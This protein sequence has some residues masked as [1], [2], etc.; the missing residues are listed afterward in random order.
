MDSELVNIHNLNVIAKKYM[1]KLYEVLVKIIGEYLNSFNGKLVTSW[2][3]QTY[4]FKIKCGRVL[5][6]V[7]LGVDNHND[8]YVVN[9]WGNVDIFKIIN[10]EI[11]LRSMPIIK[12]YNVIISEDHICTQSDCGRV[13]IYSCNNNL[14]IKHKF[15][16]KIGRRI[17]YHYNNE[18]YVTDEYDNYLHIYSIK[19]IKINQIQYKIKSTK[20]LIMHIKNDEIYIAI[21]GER[22]VKVFNKN[23]GQLIREFSNF[24]EIYN[25]VITENELIVSD[26]QLKI[27]DILTGN[28]IN[29]IDI[30]AGKDSMVINKLGQ[31]IITDRDS[32]TRSNYIFIYE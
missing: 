15:M 12:S 22:Y 1:P 14:R 21:Q 16:L 24:D 32:D 29:H 13:K 30:F 18:L 17:R 4:D 27:C 8:I 5:E 28:I 2:E 26:G 10:N 11:I 19:G 20:Y 7:Y 9:E 31:L 3:R 25:F 6:R 23:T